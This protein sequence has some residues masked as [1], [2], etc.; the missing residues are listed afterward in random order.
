MT[1]MLRLGESMHVSIHLKKLK[2]RSA[3]Y[4]NLLATVG[5]NR[6]PI[7]QQVITSNTAV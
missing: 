1:Y 6:L 5:Y 3:L 2:Q 4:F 7:S